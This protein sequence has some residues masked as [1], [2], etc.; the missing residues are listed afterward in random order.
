MAEE[1]K[2]GL[3][4]IVRKYRLYP[5]KEQEEFFSKCF[6]CV[7]F[8]YNRMLAEKQEH[9]KETGKSLRIT[10]AKYKTEFEWLK[11]VDSLALAN[12]QLHLETAYKNHFRDPKVGF[13][14]F[15]SKHGSRASYTT[16]VVNG[17]IYLEKN[18]IRLPKVGLVKIKVHRSVDEGWKLKSVTI[19]RETTGRYYASLLYSTKRNENQVRSGR[20]EK[21]LG[22]DFAM[23]G[24]AVFSD[25]TRADYP[26]YYRNAEK[27]LARE[28]RK[29]SKCQKKSNNYYKQKKKLARVHARI[30]N[31][32]SDFQHKLSH[33]LTEAYDVIV[34]EDL[35]M[36][37]MSQAL[38][39]GKSTM[40]NGY[41][42]FLTMLEYKLERKGKTFV[43]VD[44][45]YPS[46]K[47]C[48]CCGKIKAELKLSD[49]VYIC[50][51]GNV[52][53]RDINAA[54]NIRDEGRRIIGAA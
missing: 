32:R 4:N 36:K 35:N 11:E 31:Q 51:C 5:N 1:K 22:I 15:K 44:K 37:R 39:F 46:S 52:M 20:T 17:N 9:Y 53:D 38:H 48:S 18:H 28:Q 21:V 49:R 6:G 50:P 8:V 30:R 7:R 16:N 40:D 34:V 43:K 19:S 2:T 12:A 24:L 10:P 54:V 26:M 42:S 33:M 47:K 25:G 45:F 41:G 23:H 14:K 3:G 13:P 27:K 29:L